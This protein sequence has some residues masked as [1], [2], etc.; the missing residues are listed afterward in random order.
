MA[1]EAQARWLARHSRVRLL[2][3]G[4]SDDPGGVSVN[5]Q[6]AERR[7]E[8]V[9]DRLVSLGIQPE[10]LTI[11]GLGQA[12]PAAVCAEAGCA[13]HNRRVVVRI[14]DRPVAG[15]EGRKPAEVGTGPGVR[16]SLRR[17][18]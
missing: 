11:V 1:L 17:L 3:E 12:H 5:Q 9:R 18:F 8:A 15:D 6:L 7:A 16:P 4:H 14:A 10:R 13:A 2:I